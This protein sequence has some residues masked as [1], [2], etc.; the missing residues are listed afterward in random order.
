MS[1]DREQS[2][3]TGARGPRK[4]TPEVYRKLVDSYAMGCSQGACAAFAGIDRDTLKD[5]M[6]LGE[7]EGER[8]ALCR[9]LKTQMEEALARSEVALAAVVHKAA[10][11]DW[12]AARTLL[13]L[14]NPAQWS[15]KHRVEMIGG[16]G[17]VPVKIE[18]VMTDEVQRGNDDNAAG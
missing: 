9:E 7:R 4:L 12:R 8:F 10:L 18:I 13:A 2:P 14:R 1:R 16:D 17:R 5:W 11:T 3:T 6:K 15:E